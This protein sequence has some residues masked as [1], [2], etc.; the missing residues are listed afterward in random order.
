MKMRIVYA[1]ICL[2]LLGAALAWAQQPTLRL[3]TGGET[4]TY[5]VMGNNMATYCSAGLNLQVQK[6]GGTD[7]NIERLTSA[8]KAD[9]AIA[10]KDILFKRA[11]FNKDAS[12][13]NLLAVMPLYG[14]AMHVV[15]KKQSAVNT[16]T[17]LGAVVGRLGGYLGGKQGKKIGA[18]GGSIESAEIFKALSGIDYEV[19]PVADNASGLAALDKG[20]ID[21][22][23]AMGGAPLGWVGD[24]LDR[25]KHRLIPVTVS[26]ENMSQ[27]YRRIN[28]T[29][30]KLGVNALPTVATDAILVTRNFT[31]PEKVQAVSL[32]RKCITTE[33]T[34]MQEADDT[35][36]QW[37]NVQ[38]DNLQVEGWSFFAG[39][40]VTWPPAIGLPP[41]RK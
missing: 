16:F 32:L 41:R 26:M 12:V 29:Y 2:L 28:I 9:I 22:L 4:G 18:Y 15:V 13:A 25:S 27:A 10:Q 36:G 14:E 34:R 40:P 33:L 1:T 31:S 11:K 3:A 37:Q 21:A 38:K 5:Y 23:M 39:T 19:V 24:K 30:T 7:D 20:E 6:T 35:H 8:N 17:D